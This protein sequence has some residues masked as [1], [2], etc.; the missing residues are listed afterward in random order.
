MLIDSGVPF[1]SITHK[2]PEPASIESPLNEN[3]NTVCP[4]AETLKLAFSAS[5]PDT[6]II[7][8]P[9]ILN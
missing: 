7:F 1:K 4:P 5:P 9:L 2:V 6:L 3:P 8:A